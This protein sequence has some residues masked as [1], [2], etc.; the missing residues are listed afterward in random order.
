M[1]KFVFILLVFGINTQIIAQEIALAEVELVSN[2]NY[3]TASTTDMLAKPVKKLEASVLDYKMEKSSAEYDKG[4]IYSITFKI[5]EGSIVADFNNEGKII[6]TT[7][8][9]TNVRLPLEVIYAILE[10]YPNW[11]IT[12]NTYYVNYHTNKG[13]TKR[14][15]KIKLVN[16]AKSL[17][18]KTDENGNFL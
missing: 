18:I 9:Y 11:S 3:L 16:D 17:D 7:E 4:E 14:L 2:Y 5:P 8:K 1:K 12:N 15:Y 10:Q 6:S 13:I